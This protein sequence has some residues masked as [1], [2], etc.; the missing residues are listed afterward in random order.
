MQD[1]LFSITYELSHVSCK[2]AS[3]E[4]ILSQID[5]RE[6]V[7]FLKSNSIKFVL[8]FYGYFFFVL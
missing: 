1:N 8:R 7:L 5:I 4:R 6:K 2:I 3:N